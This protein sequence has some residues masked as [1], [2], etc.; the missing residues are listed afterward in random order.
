MDD[1]MCMKMYNPKPIKSFPKQVA[2]AEGA[3]VVVGGGENG[4]TH[5]FDRT[6]GQAIQ[7]LQHSNSGRVQTVTVRKKIHNDS[8]N[9]LTTKDT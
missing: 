3:T 6:T 1:A 2:L 8:I 9:R 7:T 5:V 4:C